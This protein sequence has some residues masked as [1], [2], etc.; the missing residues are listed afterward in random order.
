MQEK[1]IGQQDVSCGHQSSKESTLRAS[2]LK[3]YEAS[4]VDNV[5]VSMRD[6]WAVHAT[7]PERVHT[8][9]LTLPGQHGSAYG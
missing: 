3:I 5:T 7:Q 2:S 8:Q 1:G 4:T 6:V 9:T